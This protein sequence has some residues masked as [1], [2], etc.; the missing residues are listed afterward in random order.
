MLEMITFQKMLNLNSE[1]AEIKKSRKIPD[2]IT[3]SKS[4]IETLGKGVKYVQS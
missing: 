1:K 4:T 2:N 3:C